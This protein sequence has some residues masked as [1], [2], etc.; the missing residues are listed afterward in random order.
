MKIMKQN[1]RKLCRNK[2]ENERTTS[3]DLRKY[4]YSW[5]IMHGWARAG[6]ATRRTIDDKTMKN[7]ES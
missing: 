1:K 5:G 4:S 3:A 2:S 7:D 6:A